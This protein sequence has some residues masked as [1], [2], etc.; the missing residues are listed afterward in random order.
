M[1]CSEVTPPIAPSPRAPTPT[2]PPPDPTFPPVER[3]ARVYVYVYPSSVLPP[4]RFVFY[5]DGTFALQYSTINKFFE[6]PGTYSADG[7]NITLHFG[8]AGTGAWGA[9]GTLTDDS[10]TVKYNDIM[11]QSD[12][13]DAVYT[14][15]R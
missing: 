4:S 15:D 7:T 2:S 13:Q 8:G 10:F 11:Q 9:T 14:R 3:P 1:A 12:F 6:Y 5:D